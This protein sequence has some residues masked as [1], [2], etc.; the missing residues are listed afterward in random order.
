MSIN[1]TDDI[2]DLRDVT[3]RVDELRE[4]RDE[5][6]EAVEGAELGTLE[7]E[8]AAQA[9]NEWLT[10]NREELEEL[11]ALLEECKGLGGDHQWEGDWYPL[12]LIARDHFVDHI[13]ELIHDCYEM[14]KEMDSGRWP[15]CFMAINYEGAAQEAEADYESV[16]FRGYEFLTR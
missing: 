11:E 2:I 7:Y 12:M 6:Q 13:K 5:V 8:V 1:A 3:D 9:L 4:E 14:P 10:E 15:Y 16:D